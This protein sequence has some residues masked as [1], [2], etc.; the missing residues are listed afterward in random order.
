MARPWEEH[1]HPERATSIEGAGMT[2]GEAGDDSKDADIGMNKGTPD[3]AALV[4]RFCDEQRALRARLAGAG[5][6]DP[7]EGL[8]T[9][10][11]AHQGGP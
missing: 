11:G 1:E 9:P 10:P 7:R 4:D 6:G 2:G 8:E 5:D 3:F